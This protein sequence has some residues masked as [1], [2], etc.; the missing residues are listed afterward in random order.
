M[1]PRRIGIAAL[2]A[3][4]IAGWI[5]TRQWVTAQQPQRVCLHGDSE[6]A[7]QAARRTQALVL[8]RHINTLQAQA[9]VGP[10]P[11]YF[12]LAQLKVVR[13]TPQG[14]TVQLST[15]GASYALSVKDTLDPCRFGYFSDQDGVIFAGQPIR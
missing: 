15:D 8:V 4:V 14:F 9:Q 2:M 5:A 3:F 13:E 10:S 1:K 11:A 6:S 12:P 7:D